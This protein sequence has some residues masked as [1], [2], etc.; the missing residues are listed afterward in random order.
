MEALLYIGPPHILTR[1]LRATLPLTAVL[2]FLL[3]LR[4][5]LYFFS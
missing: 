5:F 2:F 3:R 4:V 1:G